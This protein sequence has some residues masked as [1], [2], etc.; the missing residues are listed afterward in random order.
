[1]VAVSSEMK[2]MQSVSI[3]SIRS[4]GLNLCFLLIIVPSTVFYPYDTPAKDDYNEYRKIFQIVRLPFPTATTHYGNRHDRRRITAPV[5][6]ML[7]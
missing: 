3:A 4:F 2:Y 5:A 7:S 6:C 1:M